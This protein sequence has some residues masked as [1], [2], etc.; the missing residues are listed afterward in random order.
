MKL[1]GCDL[2][3]SYSGFYAEYQSL[4]YLLFFLLILKRSRNFN[5]LSLLI[6]RFVASFLRRS[7]E[8]KTQVKQLNFS[9]FYLLIDMEVTRDRCSV[10]HI[11]T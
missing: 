9:S 5:S 7:T 1:S 4:L 6:R 8:S 3:A 11:C 10:V 2:C